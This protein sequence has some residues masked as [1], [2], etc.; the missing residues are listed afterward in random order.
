MKTSKITPGML[1]VM[2]SSD[3]VYMALLD[4]PGGWTIDCE[5]RGGS[6]LFVLAS[7][8]VMLSNLSMADFVCVLTCSGKVGWMNS[9]Y[10]AQLS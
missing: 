10:V 8:R 4:A 7:K 3:F 2:N 6:L 9:E 1:V 5:V